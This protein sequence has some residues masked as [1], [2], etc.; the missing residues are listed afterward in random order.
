MRAEYSVL[1]ALRS[2]RTIQYKLMMILFMY[3]TLLVRVRVLHQSSIPPDSRPKICCMD[4][5]DGPYGMEYLVDYSVLQ[6]QSIS[7]SD[8]GSN[9]L[10]NQ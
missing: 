2:T 7:F 8:Q 5:P 4:G 3:V 9:Q 10:A 1:C 6:A